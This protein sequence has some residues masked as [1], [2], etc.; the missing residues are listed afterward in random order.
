[1]QRLKR[2]LQKFMLT[3]L[4]IQIL[5]LSIYNTD[6]YVVQSSYTEKEVAKDDNPVD[7]FAELIV[8][9]VDG[10]Q[11]AFP[12]TDQKNEKQAPEL[13]H[14][15]TFKMIYLDRFAKIPE[16]VVLNYDQSPADL[17]V[18]QNKY[19]FLFW[20]EINHPPA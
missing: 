2:Y 7:S 12:E 3:L 4:A 16:K 1:M 17:P 15:I 18:F 11:D 9:S 19:S 14:N 20:K 6:F 8:E 10:Y 13:K 5:N